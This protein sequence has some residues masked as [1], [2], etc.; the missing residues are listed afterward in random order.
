MRNINYKVHLLKIKH[1]IH[2]LL[3][4][5]MPLMSK[6]PLH[7]MGS[8]GDTP[9]LLIANHLCI[10]DVPTAA[11]AVKKHAILLASDEEIHTLNGI[12]MNLNGVQWVRR[13]D[14]DSRRNAQKQLVSLLQKGNTCCMY[15]EATWNL[16]P[17]LLMLPMNYGCI[18]I[19]L[20][21]GVPLVPVVSWFEEDKRCTRIGNP[22][23]PEADLSVSIREL[24]DQ[25]AELVFEHI[26]ANYSQDEQGN[27]GCESRE[28]LNSDFWD[29]YVEALY[30]AYPRAKADKD[31]CR[32]FE[33]QFIFT[34]KTED[35]GFFQEFN[36]LIRKDGEKLC[37]QRI[38]SEP[39]GFY[40][41]KE[42]AFFG[43]GYNE[44]RLQA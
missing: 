19:A 31:G 26:A 29:R 41:Q 21:A 22:F 44:F 25:M 43:W 17:N 40:E 36:S 37:V 24:R 23:V 20:E 3:I 7:I 9:C 4:K 1:W 2:P 30:D 10:E 33:S 5:I 27:Y 13:L 32:N 16:S 28:Q 38:S 14:K 18:R 39:G 15:P 42:K 35:H 8:V 6:R 34:P 12:A 11:Q